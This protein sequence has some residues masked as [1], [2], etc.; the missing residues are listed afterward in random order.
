MDAA[1][2]EFWPRFL[3]SSRAPNLP[4]LDVPRCPSQMTSD[5]Q[6]DGKMELFRPESVQ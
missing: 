6:R 2:A 4:G 1:T 5:V 3:D